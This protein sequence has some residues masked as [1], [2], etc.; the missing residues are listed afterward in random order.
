MLLDVCLGSRS[1]W[2]VLLVLAEA[3]GKAVSRKEIRALT[4]MGNKMV[5][6]Y[7]ELLGQFDVILMN[8][9]G[10]RKY[11][12]FN[13]NSLFAIKLLELIKLEKEKLES[14]NFNIANLLRELA[15]EITNVAQD[16]A[17]EIILF[18][19]Y[20]KRTYTDNSDVDVALIV[21]ERNPTEELLITDSIGKLEKRF[22]KEIQIHYL[23]EK[24]F[25]SNT[26][27]AQEIKKDGIVMLP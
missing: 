22:G 17:L 23:T 11:Y 13:L 14:I 4:L 27:L 16:N 2:K 9:I 10:N 1:A 8:R 19:S 25:S 24:E 20:A 12:K 5:D 3:P 7:V 21:K 15:Y 18:G 6:K 26:K